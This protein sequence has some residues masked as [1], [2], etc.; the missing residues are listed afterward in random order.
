MENGDFIVQNG[1]FVGCAQVAC[2][3]VLKAYHSD[4]EA[5]LIERRCTECGTRYTFHR[6][7]IE[8]L[9]PVDTDPLPFAWQYEQESEAASA[10]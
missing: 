4:P 1:K 3:G 5:G 8:E 7:V 9:I 6:T 2:N 10:A